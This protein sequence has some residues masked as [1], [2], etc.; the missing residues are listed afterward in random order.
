MGA[1]VVMLREGFEASL[2][3]GIVLAFLNKTDRRDGFFAVWLGAFAA[4]AISIA[5]AIGLFAVGAELEGTAEY[6][7]E[8]TAMLLAAGLLTWMIF[9]MRRQARSIKKE[10]ESQVQTALASGSSV[11]LATVAFV[12]VLREGVETSLFFFSSVESSKGATTIVGSIVGLAAAVTLGYLF[13]KG[14]SRLDLRRFFTITSGILLLFAG[15]LLA[16]GIEEYAEAG[17]LPENELALWG[18]FAALA[19]PTLFLYF[20]PAKAKPATP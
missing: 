17:I 14:S 13:Y 16:R 3:V 7:W 19:V 9:W 6:V 10:L 4:I 15:W 18:A 2:I 11:A 1:G 8:G 5:V 12:G 20:R